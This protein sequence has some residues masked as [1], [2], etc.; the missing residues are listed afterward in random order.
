VIEVRAPLSE[1]A[2][3]SNSC[4]RNNDHASSAVMDSPAQLDIVAVERDGRIEPADLTEQ[5]SPDQH[6]RRWQR[7]HVAHAIVLFLVNFAGVDTEIDLAESVKTEADGLQRTR[8]VPFD[9]FGTN[10]ASVRTVDLFDEGADRV[11]FR[12][13]IVVAQQ[14]EPVVALDKPQHFVCGRTKPGASAE[15]SNKGIRNPHA[16]ARLE[17]LVCDVGKKEEPD[18][19]IVLIS[20][21]RERFFEPWTRFVNDD[22]RYDWRRLW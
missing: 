8:V 5:V 4:S 20:E 6:E 18:V 1:L 2:T 19:W 9:E 13:N 15:A 11:G 14:K 3:V 10:N 7:E 16:D 17:Q 22:D 12:S 21:R